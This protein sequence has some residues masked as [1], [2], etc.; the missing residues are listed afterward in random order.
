MK[1]LRV[2]APD[3]GAYFNECDYFQEDWQSAFWGPHYPRLLEVQAPLR[4]DGLFTVH[5]GVGEGWS[6]DGFEPEAS[7][8]WAPDRPF[9]PCGRRCQR[10]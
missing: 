2:C 6:A 1:A 4:P 10:S 7:R 3:T 8:V 9:S 5:H